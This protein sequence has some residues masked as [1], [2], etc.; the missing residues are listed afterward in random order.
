MIRSSTSPS[1]PGP[2]SQAGETPTLKCSPAT[3]GPLASDVPRSARGKTVASSASPGT[4]LGLASTSFP[5]YF[6]A[7]SGGSDTMDAIDVVWRRI[8]AHA[9]ETFR[10]V[11]GGEFTY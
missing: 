5:L 6:A 9:G 11:R 3:E 8:E 4:R 7:A 10:Q 2:G 1:L